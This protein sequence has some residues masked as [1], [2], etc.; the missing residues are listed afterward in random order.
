MGWKWN[1]TYTEGRGK[2]LEACLG[3]FRRK[4]LLERSRPRW[5][6]NIKVGHIK[7]E[8]EGADSLN[9]LSTGASFRLLCT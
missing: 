3:E 1:M 9:W 2:C 8:L 5:E 6:Y 7:M 4:G